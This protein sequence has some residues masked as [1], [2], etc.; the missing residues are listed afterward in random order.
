MVL[1]LVC[2]EDILGLRLELLL[3][4]FKTIFLFWLPDILWC[5]TM[6]AMQGDQEVGQVGGISE[7]IKNFNRFFIC[8]WFQS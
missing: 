3:M 7:E 5:Y 6:Q 1:I 4:M 2:V 8:G